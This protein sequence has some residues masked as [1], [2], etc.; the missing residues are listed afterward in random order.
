MPRRNPFQRQP[1]QE[2]KFPRSWDDISAAEP[3]EPGA[4]SAAAHILEIP[5]AT[6]QPKPRKKDARKRAKAR[7][8]PLLPAN[9]DALARHASRLN[10]RTYELI[11]YL[12]EYGLEQLA[13]GNLQFEPRLSPTGLTLFPDEQQPRKPRRRGV[14]LQNTT[15]RGIPDET[16]DELKKL[17]EAYPMWQVINKLLEFG[18]ARIESGDLVLQPQPSGVH[19][20]Y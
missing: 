7:K 18:I 2:T 16:W 20:L 11:R 14:K 19:T 1:D 5:A 8:I 15:C 10:V 12:L 6:W 17:A 13:L 3:A 4:N 9:K